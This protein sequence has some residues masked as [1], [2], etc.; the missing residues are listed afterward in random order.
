MTT[1][2]ESNTSEDVELKREKDV[3]HG[4]ESKLSDDTDWV[5]VIDIV[6]E[7]ELK[8]AQ[9]EELKQDK[10]AISDEH[11]KPAPDMESPSLNAEI[12][13][14]NAVELK[15]ASDIDEMKSKLHVLESK[16]NE[17]SLSQNLSG[18]RHRGSAFNDNN[19]TYS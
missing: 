14:A 12:I 10:D 3:I 6:N 17:V 7:K 1:G 11:S 8:L 2:H 13:T 9:D 4:Q 15:L 5:P 18:P 16:L 19:P